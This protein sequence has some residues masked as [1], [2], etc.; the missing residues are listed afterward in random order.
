[1]K[2][3][4]SYDF[5]LILITTL[6]L[7][8]IS[9]ICIYAMF[10]YKYAEV[11]LAPPVAQI[12]FME[13]MN[14]LVSPFL[15]ALVLV[16]GIC[17]PKRLFP[18]QWLSYFSLALMIGVL[19]ISLSLGVK[20]ALLVVLLASLLLQTLVL[21]L[22]LLG[23]QRLHFEKRGYW[24]RLGSSL[25]HLGLILFILDLFFYRWPKVHLLL[26]WVTTFSSVLGMIFCF[27]SEA[28]VQLIHRKRENRFP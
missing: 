11:H 22:A 9:L 16:L 25:I 19:V 28:I 12:H 20:M 27:Y 18:L 8:V 17:I 3:K 15:I 10:A 14:R 1:M 2:T 13:R 4:F 6:L 7:F 5:Y 24:L 26:F 23:S 21:I